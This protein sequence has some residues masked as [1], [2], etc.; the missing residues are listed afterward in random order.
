M[1]WERYQVSWK[2]VEAFKIHYGYYSNNLRSCNVGITGRRD[3]WS[4][5]LRLLHAAWYTTY[6]VSWRLQ[7]ILRFC[8]RNLWGYNVGTTDGRDFLITPLRWAQVP[9]YDICTRF[10]KDWFRH[11]NVNRGEIQTH[12]D[13]MVILKAYFHPYPCNR[14]WRPRGLWDV[15]APTFSRQSAHIWRWGCQP[16]APAA[17]YR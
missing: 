10:H 1:A 13:S 11:S 2:L 4:M 8:L 14:P 12:T 9:W 7:A 16:H 17:L 6:Q 5:P 15:E 3:L